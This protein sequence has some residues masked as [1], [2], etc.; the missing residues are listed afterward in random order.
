MRCRDKLNRRLCRP[1]QK[2]RGQHKRGLFLPFEGQQSSAAAAMQLIKRPIRICCKAA[3]VQRRNYQLVSS[4]TNCV[5]AANWVV[6]EVM[7]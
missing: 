3:H 6:Q 5:R 1:L 4:S 7:S 2:Y